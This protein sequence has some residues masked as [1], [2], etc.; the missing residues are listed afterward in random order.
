MIGVAGLN[1]DCPGEIA[2]LVPALMIELD[3]ADAA[4]GQPPCEQA[5]GGESARPGHVGSV[6]VQ[7]MLGFSREVRN[8]GHARLHAVGHLI[9]RHARF[10]LRVELALGL[11]AVE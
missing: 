6:K 7:D 8:L 11:D 4:L 3:E 5:V 9:L 10:D 1:A 2:V